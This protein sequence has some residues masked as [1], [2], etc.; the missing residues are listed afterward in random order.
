[1]DISE[2]QPPKLWQGTA[3]W[4]FVLQFAEKL[5][6]PRDGHI[7]DVFLIWKTNRITAYARIRIF[8][9]HVLSF[10]DG[11]LSRSE[12]HRPTKSIALHEFTAIAK[13]N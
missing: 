6:N 11:K 2:H 3:F 7:E 8:F 12:E 13:K 5:S 10:L 1:M 4:N 9:I